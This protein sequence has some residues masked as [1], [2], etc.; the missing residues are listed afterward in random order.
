[1]VFPELLRRILAGNALEDLCAAR[2]L[3]NEA[4]NIVDGIVDDDVLA[5]VGRVVG[6]DFGGGD[7]FGHSDAEVA[8]CWR[9]MIREATGKARRGEAT[10]SRAPLKANSI[11]MSGAR[12]CAQG[13]SAVFRMR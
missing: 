3:V 7:C 4:G 6:R 12:E 9:G 1:M 5:L 13:V 11:W 2:M 8:L 10:A